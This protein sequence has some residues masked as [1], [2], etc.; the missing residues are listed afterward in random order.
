MRLVKS[1]KHE[2]CVR[3]GTLSRVS[4]YQRKEE[5]QM[6]KY[7]LLV[8]AALLGLSGS[9]YAAINCAT[10]P[11]CSE[12]GYT[13]N[14]SRCP[15]NNVKCPMD[16]SKVKCLRPYGEFG[17]CYYADGHVGACKNYSNLVGM[18]MLS[19]GSQ[20]GV[21]AGFVRWVLLPVKGTRTWYEAK[22]ACARAGGVIAPLSYSM[23]ATEVN[24]F[25]RSIGQAG[26]W[27]STTTFWEEEE[28]A[29][30]AWRYKGNSGGVV[31][32]TER[33]MYFCMKSI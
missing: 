4:F 23:Y 29:D 30:K 13:D 28:S 26:D 14:S 19:K 33:H 18:V 11:T 22:N 21:E 3:A 31:S 12:L 6:R 20:G 15:D 7:L 1:K 5:R 17:N 27:S 32:K 16:T 9:A 25:F 2:E 10:P 8:G 24:A